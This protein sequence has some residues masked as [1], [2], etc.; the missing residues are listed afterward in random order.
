MEL[1]S[2]TAVVT[3][4]LNTMGTKSKNTDKGKDNHV[5]V[6]ETNQPSETVS[7]MADVECGDADESMNMVKPGTEAW[8]LIHSR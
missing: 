2:E 7:T 3:S 5:D 4:S 8:R 1:A 6:V